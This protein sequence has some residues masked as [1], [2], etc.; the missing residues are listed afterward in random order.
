MKE[1]AVNLKNERKKAGM[2]QQE[3]AEDLGISL[4]VYKKWEQL[5]RGSRLPRVEMQLKIADMLN[6]SLDE[7]FGR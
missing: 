1:F 3:F 6:V 5:G 2:T 4:D 7:L